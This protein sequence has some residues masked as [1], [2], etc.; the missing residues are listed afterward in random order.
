MMIT[1]I[2][3][4]EMVDR[5][6]TT[7]MRHWSEDWAGRSHN[8]ASTHWE[9]P[10][11]P[12]TAIILRKRLIAEGHPDLAAKVLLALLGDGPDGQ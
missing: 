10:L 1:G 7:S 9:K 8:F 4:N 12:E 11:P 3:Y 6:L 5:N 2:I